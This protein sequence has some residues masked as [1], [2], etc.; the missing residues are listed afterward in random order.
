MIGG[1]CTGSGAALDAALRGLN[2]ACVEREDFSSGTS[3]R[4]T[5]LIW[6]GSRYL[7]QALVRLFSLQTLKTPISSCKSFM[8]D[9]RMVRNCHR[10]RAF[11]LEKQPHLT[12]WRAVAVPLTRWLLWPPP[13]SYPPA[14]FGPMGLFS[15]FFRAYDGLSYFSCPSSHVL[16]RKRAERIFPQLEA[17]NLK[18]AQVSSFLGSNSPLSLLQVFYEGQHNDA[19][20]NVAIALSAAQQG[21]DN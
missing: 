15:L 19:R 9:F 7:V 4:S 8:A 12:N 5:K 17:H 3:S 21:S 1:G 10:E 2:V 6:A 20:T 18:Y 16:S 13:F 14:V 11:L